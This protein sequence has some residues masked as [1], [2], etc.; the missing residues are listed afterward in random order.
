MVAGGR[1]VDLISGTPE[2]SHGWGIKEQ[3][4]EHV[5]GGGRGADV[6]FW[7]LG[8]GNF[9]SGG[10]GRLTLLQRRQPGET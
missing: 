4:V 2:G 10:A 1:D 3:Y 7:G 6:M 8:V 9:G 5:G